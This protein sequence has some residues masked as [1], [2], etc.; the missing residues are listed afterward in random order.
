MNIGEL[1]LDSFMMTPKLG[2]LNWIIQNDL[3]R[4][5][6]LMIALDNERID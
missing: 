2:D 5:G 6:R 4:K 1:F 3:R